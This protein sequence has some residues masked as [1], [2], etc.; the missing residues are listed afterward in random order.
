MNRYL[1]DTNILSE[2]T[3]KKPNPD[4]V[5]WLKTVPISSSYI[6]VLTIGELRKGIDKVADPK[7][8]INLLSWLEQKVLTQFN[9]QILNI[10][11]EVADRWGRMCAEVNQPLPGIDSLLA[12]TA[13]HFDMTLVTRNLKDFNIPSLQ[14]FNPWELH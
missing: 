3:R 5:K 10:N 1:F 12:A 13:L 11:V 14:V 7:K 9:D 4:V 8:K 6:S 2:T